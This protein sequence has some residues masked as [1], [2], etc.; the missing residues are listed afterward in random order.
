LDM[1]R[2]SLTSVGAALSGAHM[3]S[4]GW[5]AMFTVNDSNGERNGMYPRKRI[6][7]LRNL[8]TNSSVMSSMMSSNEKGR[9]KQT[10]ININSNSK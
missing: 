1:D 4:I 9:R 3:V 8:A 7:F 2:E 5:V 6:Q 10:N